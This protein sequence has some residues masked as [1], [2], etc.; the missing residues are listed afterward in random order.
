M[1]GYDKYVG[2]IL[3]NRYE[4]MELIGVGGMAYVYKALC[5]RLNRLVA[6][7][8]LKEE[9]ATDEEFQ[10]RFYS[11]S[12]AVAML[13]HPNIVAVYDVSRSGNTEYIVMELIEGITLKQFINKK[14]LLNWKETLHF[15]TQIVKALTHAHS[16]GII[17]RDIKPHNIMILRDGSVK[18]ADF[19]IARHISVQ[20][21]MTQDSLGSVHYISP[22]QAKGGHIDARSDIYSVGVVMYEMLTSRLPFVGDS[23]VSVAIQ[24]ISAIPLLPRDITPDVPIGLEEITMHAMEPDVHMR[25]TT[26]DEMLCDLEEFR[27]HPGIMFNYAASNPADRQ[28]A[29]I[30]EPYHTRMIPRE[31]IAGADMRSN[32]PVV[33]TRPRSNM[34]SN[35]YRDAKKRSGSTATLVGIF[36]VVVFIVVLIT[37]FIL[38]P[39]G[40]WFNSP[41]EQIEIPNFVG[42]N[43][44]EIMRNPLYTDFFDITATFEN[45]NDV[46]KGLVISQNRT[47]GS[48]VS[49]SVSGAKITIRLVVSEGDEPPQEMPDL[50]G[51]H[52]VEARN[53]LLNM[54][55]DLQIDMEPIND[56]E[57]RDL[58][59]E[60]VPRYGDP[61]SRGNT[62]IIRYSIG[63]EEILIEIPDMVGSTQTALLAVFDELDLDA[64]IRVFEDNAAEGTVIFIARIGQM[65]P[66]GTRVTVHVSSGPPATPSPP[67]PP[68]P[69]PTPPPDPTP[70]PDPDPTDPPPDP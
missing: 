19:G 22:E 6:V 13:S 37:L 10:R 24:H 63:P 30:E 60:T 41:E 47:A 40:E 42:E 32:R 67:P 23:A 39:M 16:R 55:L 61:L 2:R 50:I 52:R 9:L 57:A 4:I 25:F 62:V 44:E 1:D 43:Y 66:P 45:N 48:M 21:T 8:I 51:L 35:E 69:T 7:K 54:Q 36:A 46:A 26:A 70:S 5:H 28:S 17:H 33:G 11:E 18:V 64:D 53:Q 20:N 65:V 34:T 14:G 49:Q 15:T 56:D 27:K 12:Q 58:I 29:D 3:D 31:A 38:P 68:S 59:I